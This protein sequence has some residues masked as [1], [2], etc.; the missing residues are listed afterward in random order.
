MIG[1]L[2]EFVFPDEKIMLPV[3]FKYKFN[4]KKD[5]HQ[6]LY[7]AISYFLLKVITSHE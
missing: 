6:L 7:V 1:A 4:Q 5:M 2:L 3:L